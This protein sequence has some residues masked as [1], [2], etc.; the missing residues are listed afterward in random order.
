MPKITL[1]EKTKRD[2]AVGVIFFIWKYDY[3]SDKNCIEVLKENI[4]ILR[5][6][7]WP[8]LLSPQ[9]KASV[10]KWLCDHPSRKKIGETIRIPSIFCAIT[11]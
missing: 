10:G 1:S 9:G 8:V 4:K 6:S 2:N 5:S 7:I 11:I 3:K